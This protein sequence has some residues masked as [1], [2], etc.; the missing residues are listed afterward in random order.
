MPLGL[1][2]CAGKKNDTVELLELA[3]RGIQ[4]AAYLT[5]FAGHGNSS[6]NGFGTR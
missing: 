6:S 3:P 5:A 1:I 2:L 4:V